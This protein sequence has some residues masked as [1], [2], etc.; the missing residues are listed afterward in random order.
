MKHTRLRL[1]VQFG[2]D[3]VLGL[4]VAKRTAPSPSS[5]VVTPSRVEPAPGFPLAGDE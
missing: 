2:F 3:R 1:A 5:A 4:L